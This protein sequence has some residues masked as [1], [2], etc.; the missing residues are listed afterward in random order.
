MAI[1]SVY[2]QSPTA[3]FPGSGR[4]NEPKIMIL[5][6]STI[7]AHEAATGVT[8]ACENGAW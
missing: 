1:K 7:I 2:Y 4:K 3:T 8:L 6:A 5:S